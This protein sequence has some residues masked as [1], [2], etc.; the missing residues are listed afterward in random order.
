MT[1]ENL[2]EVLIRAKDGPLTKREWSRLMD[3]VT[4]NRNYLSFKEH[5]R[6][7]SLAQ[8]NPQAL[9][10]L[11]YV[12]CYESALFRSIGVTRD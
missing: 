6:L 3:E 11:Q 10:K 8:T 4:K 9:T 2:D 5:E 7:V 12:Q 1:E